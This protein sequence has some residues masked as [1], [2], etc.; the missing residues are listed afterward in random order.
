MSALDRLS[1]GRI[2]ALRA[3]ARETLPHA[4]AFLALFVL[5]FVA[6]VRRLEVV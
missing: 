5:T 3:A 1:R 6:A 4:A 2:D